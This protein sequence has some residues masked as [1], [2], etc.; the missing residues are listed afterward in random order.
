MICLDRGVVGPPW[1]KPGLTVHLLA[2]PRGAYLTG[3]PPA[4]PADGSLSPVLQRRRRSVKVELNTQII[5]SY[6][7]T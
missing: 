7:L 2:A 6:Y 3:A 4:P 1:L 5:H